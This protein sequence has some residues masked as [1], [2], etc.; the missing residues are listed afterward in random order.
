MLE[1]KA[2]TT[3]AWLLLNYT[4][5]CYL[6]F[7]PW[8]YFIIYFHFCRCSLR[9]YM[10]LSLPAFPIWASHFS[11][12]CIITVW[13]WHPFSNFPPYLTP[14][15]AI[16]SPSPLCTYKSVLP[17][18]YQSSVHYPFIIPFMITPHHAHTSLLFDSMT[19]PHLFLYPCAIH[20]SNGS[21]VT[22][23]FIHPS[24]I[25]PCVLFHLV[26]KSV[27]HSTFWHCI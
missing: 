1:L 4:C 22:Q 27:A 20:F 23:F 8:L 3:N 15:S 12:A 2:C 10:S 7:H 21:S 11:A 9:L 24:S 13:A 16:V 25:L 5:V 14:P 6:F 26:F 17:L 19:L 18:L